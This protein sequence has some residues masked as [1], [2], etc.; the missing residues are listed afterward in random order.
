MMTVVLKTFHRGERISLSIPISL[1]DLEQMPVMTGFLFKEMDLRL[2]ESI[3]CVP[4][5]RTWEV[6][7]YG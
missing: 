2:Y 6:V 5:E 3:G 4:R 7:D 1:I